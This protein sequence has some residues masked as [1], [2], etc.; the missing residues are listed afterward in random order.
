M[1]CILLLLLGVTVG[2]GCDWSEGLMMADEP[3]VPI[4]LLVYAVQTAVTT[5]T[6]IAE[7]LSWGM[8]GREKLSLVGGLYAPYLGVCE[9]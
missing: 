7:A 2:D 1:V 8:M 5:L 6:C 3:R 9:S 4:Y